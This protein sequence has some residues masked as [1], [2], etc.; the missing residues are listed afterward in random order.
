ME[1]QNKNF[2]IF[3]QITNHS[4]PKWADLPEIDLYMDQVIA[5]MEKYLAD[6]SCE[7][8]KLI[9]PSM[10]NNYVKLGIMPAPNKKK[11]SRD[12]LAYLVIIC[13]LKQVIPIS[14]IKIMIEKKLQNNTIAETLDFY[15]S[16]YDFTFE[17]LFETCKNYM[18]SNQSDIKTLDDTSL[19]TA[20][21]AANCINISNKLF[22]EMS[23]KQ[24]EL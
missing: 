8:S 4:I 2:E 19:F 24:K 16:L 5:L 1:K 10:I 17:T 7:D 13:S 12:H 6:A 3:Q 11:Y 20:I 22:F 23:K 14:N 9:T 18:N 15:S 21:T